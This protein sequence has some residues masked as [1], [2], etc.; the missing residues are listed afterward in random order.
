ML[1]REGR[2]GRE[3]MEGR[4][5]RESVDIEVRTDGIE[6]SSSLPRDAKISSMSIREMVEFVGLGGSLSCN[7]EHLRM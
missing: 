4:E 2:D 1:D 6:V 7:I 5:G 3:E